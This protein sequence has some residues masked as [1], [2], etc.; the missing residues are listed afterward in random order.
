MTKMISFF[1]LPLYTSYL[2]PDDYGMYDLGLTYV[3]FFC[4][5][6]YLDIWSG[7]MRFMYDFNGEDRKKPISCGIVIFLCSTVIYT[8]TLSFVFPWLH[9]QYPGLLMLYG[10]LMNS[11]TLAGYIAR[12]YGKTVIYTVSGIVS[13]LVTT[14]LNILL[15]VHFH[16]DYSALIISSCIGFLV[17]ILMLVLGIRVPGV[18]SL[19][20]F[21]KIIF[22]DML[23]F[24]LPLCL[25]SVAYWFLT[26]YNRVVIMD[27][28]GPAVNGYYAVAGRFGSMIALFTTG[29]TMAWQELSYS[30]TAH[31]KDLGQFYTNAINTYIKFMGSGLI[32]LIPAVSIIYP[33]L[34]NDSF[35]TG[36]TLVPLYLL[37]TILSTISV[38]V[39]NAFTAIKKNNYLFWTMVIGGACNVVSI[40]LLVEPVGIQASNLALIIGFTGLI[41]SQVILFNKYMRVR[42]DMKSVSILLVSFCVVSLVYFKC[43]IWMNI[44]AVLGACLVALYLFKDLIHQ[45]IASVKNKTKNDEV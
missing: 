13:S 38:F 37:G 22:K 35:D 26:S 39:G 45:I 43:N 8:I 42:I 41:L 20:H 29:F 24:S 6:C 9:V 18:F 7:I 2:T 21:N 27:R 25:N 16:M 32:I 12:G 15:L 17:N 23:I 11:Q 31:S 28:M 14:L 30:K 4:S 5:V 10:A 19:R 33:L 44:L 34:V 1:L 40:H 3:M 36:K